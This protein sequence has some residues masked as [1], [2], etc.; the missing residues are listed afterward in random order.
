MIDFYIGK[1]YSFRDFNCWDYV[2]LV[3]SENGIKTR[4]Y[5]AVNLGN[6][7]EIITAEMQKLG[8]GLTLVSNPADFDII[9]AHKKKGE[10]LVYHCGLYYKGE[11]MHCDRNLKQVVAQN[12]K[13]FSQGFEGV[14]IWR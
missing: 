4:K 13:E 8:N 11:I 12:Y 3:R 10:S 6:A 14:K 2:A 5:Q 9:I 1:P 7:F